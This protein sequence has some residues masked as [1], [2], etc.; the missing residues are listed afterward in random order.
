[1]K[2]DLGNP[3]W[4]NTLPPSRSVASDAPVAACAFSR[5]GALVGFGLGDGRVRLMSADIKQPASAIAEPVHKGAVLSLIGDPTSD[6]FVS[7]GDDGLLLRLALDGGATEIANQKGKWIDK[8]AAHRATG[9]IAASAGKMALVVD[10]TGAVREFGPHPSTVAGLDFSKDGSRIAAAHYD[11]ITVWSIGAV[12]LPPKRLAWRGSHVALKWSTDGKF[13]ATGT[14]ENDIHVWRVAQSTDMRMQGY[15]AKVKSLSWS[16]DAR[17]LYTS[18][19]PVFTAWPFAGNGPEGKPPLQFGDEGAGLITVVA[20]HPTAAEYV[21]GG[22]DS[23][24]L[25]IGDIKT[26]RSAVLRMSDGAAITCLAWSPD[27]FHLAVG[28]ENGDML[29]VDLRR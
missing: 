25:Q 24:E 21:A 7:G 6:G 10:K 14:Q 23:G 22:Y 16:A 12:T 9:A 29:V 26:R 20:A 17:W 13:I 4:R 28:N 11:G 19:Q 2:L 1:M 15:P 3:A 5:D 18:S 27:G 8:L